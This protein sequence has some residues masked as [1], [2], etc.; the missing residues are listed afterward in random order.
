MNGVGLIG[1]GRWARVLASVLPGVWDGPVTVCSPGHPAAWDDRPGGW[2]L[3]ELSDLLA[4]PAIGHVIIARRA[5]DHASTTLAALRAR[6]SVLVEKPFCLTR[7][8]ADAILA[9]GGNCLTG[10]VFLHAPNQIRFRAALPSAPR[11][12]RIE[13]FDSA[14]E[15]RHGAIK[16]FDPALNVVQD[17]LP[18]VW[19]LIR[20]LTTGPLQVSDARIGDG[21]LQVELV[22]TGATRIEISLRRNHDRRHRLLVAEGEG[23]AARLDFATEPGQASL[24]EAVLDVATGHA[25]PLAAELR[26]FLHGPHAPLSEAGQAV[27]ALD[28]T[29]QAMRLI[30]PL[31]AEAILAGDPAALREVA[32]GGLAGDGVPATPADVACW[33]GIGSD[34]APLHAT[35]T[36]AFPSDRF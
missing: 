32:L 27:E 21:G 3:A 4:D 12:I 15:R 2:S 18:H 6:K 30:R 13:W 35:W 34:P 22:L 9:Q 7:A 36:G 28:L 33:L 19:S 5:R 16:G 20:P 25:S 11:H 29:L 31:Q 1:G 26:A 23:F 14:A 24:N 8:E 17:V 10:L